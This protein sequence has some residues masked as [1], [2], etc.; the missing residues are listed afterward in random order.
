MPKKTNLNIVCTPN[1]KEFGVLMTV[2]QYEQLMDIV[3]DYHDYLAVLKYSNLK[4]KTYTTAE[5]LAAANK[6]TSNKKRA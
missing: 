5:I 3:D 1:G 2:K 4:G 6:P